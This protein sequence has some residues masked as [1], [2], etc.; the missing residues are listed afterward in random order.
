MNWR[1]TIDQ[2]LLDLKIRETELSIQALQTKLR[3]LKLEREE[4]TSEGPDTKVPT[5]IPSCSSSS[6][7]EQEQRE[8]IVGFWDRGDSRGNK[9]RIHIGDIVEVLTP[10]KGNKHFAKGVDAVVERR[11]SADRVLISALNDRSETTNRTPNNLRVKGR[12]VAARSD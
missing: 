3:R 8:W 12:C 4:Y 1:E 9:K 6:S 10:S 5:K 2:E 11:H 7:D